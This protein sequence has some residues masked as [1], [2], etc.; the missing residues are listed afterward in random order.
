MPSHQDIKTSQ[1]HCELDP[2][3]QEY[4]FN[5]LSLVESNVLLIFDI[6]KQRERSHNVK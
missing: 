3:A 4:L 6:F 2:V 1:M 5:L